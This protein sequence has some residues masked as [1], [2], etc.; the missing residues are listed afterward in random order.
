MGAPALHPTGSRSDGL[1]HQHGRSE[2]QRVRASR[3]HE[4]LG[5]PVFDVVEAVLE[6]AR[7]ELDGVPQRKS[8]ELHVSEVLEQDVDG[9]G[10]AVRSLELLSGQD[11][12]VGSDELVE[13]NGAEP[14]VG[15]RPD[16]RADLGRHRLRLLHHRRLLT[17]DRGLAGRLPHADHDG[18]RRRRDGPLVTRHPARCPLSAP[19]AIRTTMRSPKP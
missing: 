1:S 3:G 8:I 10:C 2:R 12:L 4:P 15:Y 5:H 19:W 17:R 9:I 14:A 6:R 11:G 13:S 18:P 7:I 16:L